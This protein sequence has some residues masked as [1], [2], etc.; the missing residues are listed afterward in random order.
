MVGQ[1]STLACRQL[2]SEWSSERRCCMTLSPGTCPGISLYK[3]CDMTLV[4]LTVHCGVVRG[5]SL[6]SVSDMTPESL[7]VHCGV[8]RGISLYSVS[9]MT[10]VSLTVQWGRRHTGQ[11]ELCGWRMAGWIVRTLSIIQIDRSNED[12]CLCS[13]ML[14]PK[15][16][17]KFP[18][19]LTNDQAARFCLISSFCFYHDFGTWT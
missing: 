13:V 11:R 5:I 12:P 2:V 16:I 7:T 18:P 14:G 4:S 1:G 9:D 3:V 17:T 6:G 15:E 8:V 10:L 19:K